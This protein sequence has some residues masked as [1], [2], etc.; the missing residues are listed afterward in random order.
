MPDT[1]KLR[2]LVNQFSFHSKPSNGN[3]SDPC[4]IRDL[5][6]VIKNVSDLFYAFID[7]LEKDEMGKYD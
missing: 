5:N 6:K 3:H 1:S 2:D 7:E 4:T